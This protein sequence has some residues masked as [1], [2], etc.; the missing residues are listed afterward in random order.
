MRGKYG[1]TGTCTTLPYDVR[2]QY[3]SA[4]S[5]YDHHACA[6]RRGTCPCRCHKEAGD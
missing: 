3:S 2:L 5:R 6:G 1:G 4:C